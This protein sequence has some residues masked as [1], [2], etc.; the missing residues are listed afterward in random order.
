MTEAPRVSPGRTTHRPRRAPSVATLNLSRR[1]GRDRR[2]AWAPLFAA[3]VAAL[4]WLSAGSTLC[5]QQ[6]SSQT[7]SPPAASVQDGSIGGVTVGIKG[8]YRVGRATAIRVDAAA[9]G[10]EAVIGAGDAS[11][12]KLETAKLE[13]VKLE[14]LDGDG[15]RTRYDC[16]PTGAGNSERLRSGDC[17]LGYI[18]P[19]SEAAPL[20]VLKQVDGVVETVLETRL[21]LQGV[22]SRGPSMIPAAMPWVVCIGDT[23]GIESIGA[24]NILVDKAARIAVTK[25][26]SANSLPF[27]ALGYDGV[28]LVMINAAGLPVLSEMTADQH[29][30]L[31]SWM[32]RGG[33]IF[34]CLGRSSEQISE[35]APW[36][37]EAI[38]VEGVTLSR[39]DPAA[40]EVF[41]TSQNPLPEFRG[42]KL[43]KRGGRVIVAGRTTRRVSAV[44][45]AEYVVGFGLVT[46][47]AADLDRQAFADWPERLRLVTQIV[48]DLFSDPEADRG[49]RDGTTSYTDLAGQ[50]RST[51]DQF[52]IKPRFSF[53][54]VSLVVM[55][56]I[57]AIGPLD[58]LL[59]NR[60]WGKPLLGWLTF[61]IVTISLAVFLVFQSQPRTAETGNEGTGDE[62]TSETLQANQFQ[63]TDIDLVN[64]VGRGFAWCSIYS[65]EPTRINLRYAAESRL[66]AEPSSG[67]DLPRSFVFPMGYSGKEFGGIQ[68]AGESTVFPDYMIK[69]DESEASEN[70]RDASA[71]ARDPDAQ[72]GGDERSGLGIETSVQELTIAPRS[73]KSLATRVSFVPGIEGDFTLT[74]RPS[75][76]LLR[77]RFINPLPYDVLDGVLIYGNWVYLLPTRIP[78]GASLPQL[79]EL[80]QKNFRWRLT[81]QQMGEE[82]N[83]E[84]VPWSASDYSSI[85]RV[86]EMMM[87]HRAAGGQIYT[88]LRHDML[89]GLDL[90]AVLD[91]DRCILVGRT[92]T[93]LFALDVQETTENDS[94]EYK[95]RS[96]KVLSIIRVIMPVRASRLN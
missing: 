85:Q 14:T 86:A 64:R 8:H 18:V 40:F 46:V 66:H 9:L 49:R 89:G 95:Q 53:S 13:T 26:E 94:E 30:A 83:T 56:L 19:G 34:A 88:G 57:A 92:E 90:S 45:A 65:H 70:Q 5:A 63:V 7:D 31:S 72:Q 61:P 81:G 73:S 41:A 33:R 24:S 35:A 1:L 4:V 22:P 52:S 36:L 20:A 74:R 47:V 2:G 12:A 75:S 43:P 28:D 77:G 39:L 58:Y 84:S 67:A 3:M 60:V 71:A 54:L 79:N 27:H 16:F 10:D 17:E 21:P 23:F 80:R 59:I 37:I 87:F 76:E 82:S 69:P 91:E 29:D 96:G 42:I 51:L 93:P 44:Q 6:D 50:M 68:L 15:V 11:A 78:A 32:R 48:G 25:I 62:A 55:L 38:P